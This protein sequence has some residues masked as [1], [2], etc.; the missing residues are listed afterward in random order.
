MTRTSTAN[1]QIKMLQNRALRVSFN[2][3]KIRD[4]LRHSTDIL[5]ERVKVS[6]LNHRRYQ[7]LLIYGQYLCENPDNIDERNLPT[8]EIE[9]FYS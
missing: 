3:H 5:H 2:Q 6:R 7:H 4:D 1:Q 9:N 8:W